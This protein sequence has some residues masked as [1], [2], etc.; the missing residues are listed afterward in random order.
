MK[1]LSAA[2]VQYKQQVTCTDHKYLYTKLNHVTRLRH[3]YVIKNTAPKSAHTHN[4]LTSGHIPTFERLVICF[5][6][7][8]KR[9]NAGIFKI[10]LLKSHT[11]IV[12]I[13][14]GRMRGLQSNVCILFAVHTQ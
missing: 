14:A 13:C 8:R 7:F 12:E 5:S 10:Y 3:S 11:L 9:P 6:N 1:R 2:F 4:K